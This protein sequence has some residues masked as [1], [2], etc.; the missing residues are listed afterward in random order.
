MDISDNRF[1]DSNSG[2]SAPSAIDVRHYRIL[3][4]HDN[5]QETESVSVNINVELPNNR[6]GIF[7]LIVDNI[8]MGSAI[9]EKKTIDVTVGR[10]AKEPARIDGL[11][12]VYSNRCFSV[13]L[14]EIPSDVVEFAEGNCS[15]LPNIQA[16]RGHRHLHTMV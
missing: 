15:A 9:D 11:V 7:A 14:D 4:V 10:L 2:E 1:T 5:V 12:R 13:N 3:K 6:G 8:A 16:L